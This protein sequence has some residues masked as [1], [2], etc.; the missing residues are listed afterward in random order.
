MKSTEGLKG[1]CLRHL[2]MSLF[3]IIAFSALSYAG[4]IQPIII[5]NNQGSATGVNFQ[6]MIM[7]NAIS[8]SSY[9]AN[10]LGNIRFYQGS[11][12]LYS[13]CESGCSSFSPNAIFW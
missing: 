5:T 11:N 9:E 12:Q 2:T 6:Q 4:Y 13:W 10:D 7:F 3:L 8:Y 1:S